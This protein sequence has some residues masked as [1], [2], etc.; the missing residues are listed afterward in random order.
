MILELLAGQKRGQLIDAHKSHQFLLHIPKY[1]LITSI[2]S[3]P[4]QQTTHL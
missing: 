1:S 2:A 3:S 4:L